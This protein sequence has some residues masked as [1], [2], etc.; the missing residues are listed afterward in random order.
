MLEEMATQE[1][2]LPRKPWLRRGWR[3]EQDRIGVSGHG[4]RGLRKLNGISFSLQNSRKECM[5]CSSFQ[6]CGASGNERTAYLTDPA[7]SEAFPVRGRDWEGLRG[8]F[9]SE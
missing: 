2:P 7:K 9:I 6:R 5:C 1:A 4:E 3:R 8:S